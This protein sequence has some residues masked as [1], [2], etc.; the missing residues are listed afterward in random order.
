MNKIQWSK[1]FLGTGVN[2]EKPELKDRSRSGMWDWLPTMQLCRVENEIWAKSRITLDNG[3]VADPFYQ[4]SCFIMP[5]VSSSLPKWKEDLMSRDKKFNPF[6]LKVK[7]KAT[8]SSCSIVLYPDN[9]V[10][11]T[12]SVHISTVLS[13]HNIFLQGNCI[14]PSFTEHFYT[15]WKSSSHLPPSW[16]VI[17]FAYALLTLLFFSPQLPNDLGKI[18]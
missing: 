1:V 8:I 15:L 7:K 6:V 5:C 12:R 18:T 17:A 2:A 16:F 10:F 11:Q 14:C 3:G 9:Y 13:T 4:L